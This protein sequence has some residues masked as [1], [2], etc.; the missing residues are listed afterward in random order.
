MVL[1]GHHEAF[2]D[3]GFAVLLIVMVVFQPMAPSGSVS[4]ANTSSV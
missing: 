1:H 4:A 2:A 3:I